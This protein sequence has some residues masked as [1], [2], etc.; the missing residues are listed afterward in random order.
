MVLMIGG[1][2]FPKFSKVRVIILG[3]I[4][5]YYPIKNDACLIKTDSKIIEVL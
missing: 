5:C 2:I 1:L 3:L 4:K